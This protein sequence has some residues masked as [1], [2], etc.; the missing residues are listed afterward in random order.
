[1]AVSFIFI[2]LA[3][4][5][6]LLFFKAIPKNS[7]F[8]K[9]LIYKYYYIYCMLVAI[10]QFLISLGYVIGVANC[11]SSNPNPSI[12]I[13]ISFANCL[14]LLHPLFLC[15][16]RYQHPKVKKFISEIFH[17]KKEEVDE[18]DPLG[19]DLDDQEQETDYNWLGSLIE[20]IRASQVLSFLTGILITHVEHFPY[21]VKAL[22]T[23][24]FRHHYIFTISEETANNYL[25]KCRSKR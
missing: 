20:S 12:N 22:R 23:T 2:I 3:L 18:I 10:A 14:L 24:D 17:K 11:S 4:T 6:V 19:D 5:S 7:F 16:I 21:K 25:E 13:F 15:F 8:R 9:Q 1:M